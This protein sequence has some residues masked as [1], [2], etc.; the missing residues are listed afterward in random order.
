MHAQM[1]ELKRLLG[2]IKD[3]QSAAA[4]LEWDQATLMPPG[5]AA[6]RAR[7]LATLT[8]LAHEK[9]T[10]PA[11]GKLLEELRPYES[12]LPYDS[13]EAGLIRV[14]RYDFERAIRVPASFLAGFSAHMS[15]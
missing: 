8:R 6:A 15:E 12:D 13:D 11:L 5:G 10:D 7:Q 9:L 1:Q 14:A 3:L 4:V 2:E